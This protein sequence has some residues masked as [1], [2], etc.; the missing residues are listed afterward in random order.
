MSKKTENANQ[1]PD[2]LIFKQDYTHCSDN[3]FKSCK[4]INRL[5]MVLRYYENLD[6]T[7][8]ND[9]KEK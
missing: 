6:V 7:N 4:G 2:L 1:V 9:D 8:N 5:I 3:N